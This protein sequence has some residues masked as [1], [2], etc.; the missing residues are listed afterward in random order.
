MIFPGFP[1]GVGTLISIDCG[2]TLMVAFGFLPQIF[3]EDGRDLR[4]VLC[5]SMNA[6]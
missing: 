2:V 3:W 1:G 4:I 5:H 6:G